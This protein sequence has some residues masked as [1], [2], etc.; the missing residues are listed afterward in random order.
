MRV[1]SCRCALD[2][3]PLDRRCLHEDA[4]TPWTVDA[5]LETQEE[6]SLKFPESSLDPP[7]RSK[8]LLKDVERSLVEGTWFN[9][10]S[11]PHMKAGLLWSYLVSWMTL[12]K[13]FPWVRRVLVTRIAM[14]LELEIEKVVDSMTSREGI[15]EKVRAVHCS[16]K[17]FERRR[18]R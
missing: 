4:S 9:A 7:P 1:G 3:L 2:A 5:D 12:K 14:V 17:V 8:K 6:T 15:E 18:A 16:E 11:R 10:M 13:G